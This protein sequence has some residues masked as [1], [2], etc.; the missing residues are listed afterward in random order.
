MKQKRKQ[1]AELRRRLTIDGVNIKPRRQR[2]LRNFGF[3]EAEVYMRD[4]VRQNTM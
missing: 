3:R 2:E 1:L 4:R